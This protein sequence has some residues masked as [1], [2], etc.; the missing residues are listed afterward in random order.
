MRQKRLADMD[1]SIRGIDIFL[2]DYSSTLVCFFLTGRPIIY[3][4]LPNAVP[5]PEYAEMFAAMYTARSWEEV[6]HYLAE[7]IAGNDPLFERR[8]T[9]A[10]KIFEKHKDAAEKIVD[11]LSEDF[12]APPLSKGGHA[13]PTEAE[14]ASLFD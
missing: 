10:Q 7:L 3:C 8:Q 11:W 12:F 6:E 2:A 13:E 9:I 14:A 1:K 5:F 4:E